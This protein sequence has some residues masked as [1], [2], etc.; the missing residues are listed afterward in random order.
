MKI[1]KTNFKVGAGIQVIGSHV[2]GGATETILARE[3]TEGD[4]TLTLRE[5]AGAP[6]WEHWGVAA[7]VNVGG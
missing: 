6:V 7:D 1:F 2:Q 4:T 3:V 5:F